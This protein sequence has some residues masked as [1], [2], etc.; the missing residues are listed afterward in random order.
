MCVWRTSMNA[1]RRCRVGGAQVASRTRTERRRGSSRR[2][3]REKGKE[4]NSYMSRIHRALHCKCVRC[5]SS[6]DSP[7]RGTTWNCGDDNACHN[8]LGLLQ[9]GMRGSRQPAPFRRAIKN[10]HPVTEAKSRGI[11][12]DQSVLMRSMGYV[13]LDLVY[14]EHYI[15]IKSRA[16]N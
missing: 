9:V 16:R 1:G 12:A 8:I 4:R 10:E 13:T 3:S 11:L 15:L 7:S 5:G 14:N 6:A 2:M